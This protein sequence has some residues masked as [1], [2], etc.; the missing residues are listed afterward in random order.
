MFYFAAANLMLAERT[1]ARNR[2]D[3]EPA[4]Q[5]RQGKKKRMGRVQVTLII[6]NDHVAE[7]LT[8]EDTMAALEGTYTD[9]GTH[10][11]VCRPRIDLQIPTSDE[12]KTYQ[13]GTMEGGSTRGYFA[14]RMKSDVLTQ[15]MR[16]DVPTEEKY[17]VRPGLWCGLILLTSIETGEPLAFLNDGML[18]H[19]RVGADGGIG[20]KY[21]A[22]KDAEVIGM[23]GSG[24]MSRSHMESITCVR[25]IKKLQVWSPTKANR[26]AF[27]EEVRTKYGIEVVVCD[28][29][30]EVYRGADILAALTDATEPVTD[31]AYLEPG[32]HIIVIG[33]SGAPDD[34]SIAKIDLSLRFGNAPQPWGL[35]TFGKAKSRLTYAAMTEEIAAKRMS[36]DAKRGG[37]GAVREDRIVWLA[38]IIEGRS[39]GRTSDDQITYSERGNLQG[40]QFHAVAGRA[41][42]LARDAGLGHEIPTSWLLQ[43]IRD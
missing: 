1:A 5:D 22:R 29:P 2:A 38:D 11:A 37:R 42:E 39:A 4:R 40:V 33:S 18:Q 30:E 26:E 21:M 32:T 35:E 34:A 25:D 15:E 14:I 28:N 9:L 24:G 43:D 16:G 10:H 7:V 20:T 8:M 23:L 19:M 41:Y 31:G 6:N 36:P 3:L 27:G 12:N 17:C 13:W